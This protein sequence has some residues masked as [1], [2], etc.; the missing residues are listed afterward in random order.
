MSLLGQMKKLF[1]ANAA[2]V[3]AEYP[4][5][6]ERVELSLLKVTTAALTPGSDERLVVVTSTPA[7]LAELQRV[8]GPL[9]MISPG[10][11]TVTWVPVKKPAVP[12]L[13]PD[14]GWIIPLTAEAREEIATLPI[15]AGDVELQT[16]HL[17]FILESVQ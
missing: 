6:Y 17:A 9:Q 7:A 3:L 5:E 15:V 1:G 14:S 2:P 11:R 13:D 10:A 12:V 4:T 16:M 8:D